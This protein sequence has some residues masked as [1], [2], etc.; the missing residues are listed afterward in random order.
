MYR[1]HL[2]NVKIILNYC[3]ILNLYDK[4]TVNTQV[5]KVMEERVGR[6]GGPIRGE[7]PDP[8][9]VQLVSHIAVKVKANYFS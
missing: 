4:D 8:N 6:E 1:D 2:K 5:D 9:M 7:M 3:I